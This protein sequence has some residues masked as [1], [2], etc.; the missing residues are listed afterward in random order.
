MMRSLSFGRRPSTPMD[1]REVGPV[2]GPE[3]DRPLVHGR[4]VTHFALYHP[5]LNVWEC[6]AKDC[7]FQWEFMEDGNPY[8]HGMRFCPRCGRRIVRGVDADVDRAL[9]GAMG[10]LDGEK[11]GVG[12]GR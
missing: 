8:E 7:R 2:D 6:Q 1:L 3:F 12:D 5:D 9:G 10:L 4:N 11:G